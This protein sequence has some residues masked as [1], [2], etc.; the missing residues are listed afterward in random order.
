METVATT[1]AGQVSGIERGGVL[2][3]AGIPFAAPPVGALRWRA[4]RPPAPWTGVAD[5]SSFGKVSVQT[6]GALESLAGGGAVDW[7]EDCLTLNVYT[8][9][10]DDAARPVMV[11]IHGG[12]FVTGAGSVP[13]YDGTRF[14]A[15]GD[16]VVVTVNYRLGA[17]GWLSLAHLDPDFADSGN[18]GL[19]DQVAAL[20]WV[21]DNISGFGGDPSNVTIFGESAGGMSV[22][23][24]LGTPAAAGL[25]HKSIAQSGAAHNVATVDMA[26]EVTERMFAALGVSDLAGLLSATPE[27][28]LE[29]QAEVSMTL[30]KERAQSP[31]GAGLG[32]PFGPVVDGVV[33]SRPPLD[34]VRDGAA[35][36]VALMTGT[37][38]EE[39]KLFGLML[40][41]VDDEATILRRLG[42]MVED[43]HQLVAAYRQSSDDAS[44]DDLWQAI[45]TD[46]IFR[47]PAIRLAEA[48]LVHQPANTF[49]YLFEWSS[50][51]FDGRLGSCHALEIPFV[52]DNLDQGGV[53]MFTG[54][55]APQALADAMH[56]SWLAFARHGNPNHDGIPAWPAYD[57]ADRATLHFGDSVRVEHDPA[58]AAR[59]A[60]DGLL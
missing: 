23:T 26:V 11:W 6:A 51:A 7:S 41:S 5:A 59:A 15:N 55:D 17:L 34:A 49:S 18:L 29:V 47:I 36:G 28:L 31:S 38:A 13:W 58:P 2:R 60:W 4:P 42:R 35:A 3:F 27:R 33:L 46:R 14:V 20:E 32:L 57:L 1:T 24:L 12:G 44:H 39:W 22:A 40:R 53:E 54:P 8:P 37:T 45:L 48:Q 19:L 9:A 43:P 56:R 30:T 21:R 52:F 10:L 16:V 50:T 25:F